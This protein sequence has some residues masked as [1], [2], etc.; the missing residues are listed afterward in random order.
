MPLNAYKLRS[1]AQT[2]FDSIN[3][4]IN[5]RAEKLK[6]EEVPKVKVK[7][8]PKYLM[9]LGELNNLN[10]KDYT[11]LQ[12]IKSL[13]NLNI[14]NFLYG[15][16]LNNN[17]IYINATNSSSNISTRVYYPGIPVNRANTTVVT[18]RNPEN[19]KI[20]GFYKAYACYVRV[21]GNT[22]EDLRLRKEGMITTLKEM[23]VSLAEFVKNSNLES[24]FDIK[25]GVNSITGGV[26]PDR[27]FPD[28][29]EQEGFYTSCNSNLRYS[30]SNEVIVSIELA[31]TYTDEFSQKLSESLV[32]KA[33]TAKVLNS[34]FSKFRMNLLKNSEFSSLNKDID[35]ISKALTSNIP[36]IN[37]KIDDINSNI[38]SEIQSKLVPELFK[39]KDNVLIPNE[40]FGLSDTFPGIV[41]DFIKANS[42][43]ISSQGER[44]VV[45][46]SNVV[47]SYLL[48][49]VFKCKLEVDGFDSK[50]W[51][52]V[53][54]ELSS[55]DQNKLNE[56]KAF[57]ESVKTQHSIERI[58]KAYHENLSF[59]TFRVKTHRDEYFR[60][61]KEMGL[62]LILGQQF[63]TVRKGVIYKNLLKYYLG[64]DIATVKGFY[65]SKEYSLENI[66]NML[67]ETVEK[68]FGVQMEETEDTPGINTSSFNY[69]TSPSFIEHQTEAMRGIWTSP[70]IARTSSNQDPIPRAVIEQLYD[71][72]E[73]ISEGN[74][75]PIF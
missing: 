36:E 45:S 50:K 57:D 68:S 5:E 59:A 75:D 27:I 55:L 7:Y 61:I 9:H 23:N 73:L 3:K 60:A 31:V 71:A 38:D 72:D 15:S 13:L 33:D 19:S 18:L 69:I 12:R 63:K 54:S 22:S 48:S 34:K 58:K 44:S 4:R 65:T 39:D 28:L 42:E 30:N 25:L 47:V 20:T 46:N 66:L 35:S 14:V 67:N 29:K 62:L 70:V 24:Y 10:S 40:I 16:L 74:T 6:K 52:E 37:R 51:K 11:P 43:A 26:K 2:G 8:D 32:I 49:R 53:I 17:S 21:E 64:N 41:T 56:I 1:S